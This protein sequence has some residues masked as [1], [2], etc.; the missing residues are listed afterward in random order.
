MSALGVLDRSENFLTAR[1]TKSGALGAGFVCNRLPV[2]DTIVLAERNPSLKSAIPT[3]GVKIS[4][5]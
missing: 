1:A 3:N 2:F 5:E 4:T